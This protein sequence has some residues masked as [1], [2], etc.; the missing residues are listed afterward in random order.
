MA[1]KATGIVAYNALHIMKRLGLILVFGLGA[2]VVV[3]GQGTLD[4][5]LQDQLKKLFPNATSFSSKIAEP[6][7]YKAY[8]GDPKAPE[9]LIGLAFWTTELT[10]LDRGYD[11]PI[12]VLVGMTPQ[13]RL[14]GIV[15]AE[16]KEPYGDFSIDTARFQDQFRNK[17]IRDQFKVGTDINAIATATISITTVARSVRNSGRRVAR[18]L[19]TPPGTQ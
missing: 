15:V 10:P 17:D 18:A 8:A 1:T 11:G 3:N 12:K 5:K 2:L 4:K 14:T 13:A 7:H 16:H 19:L 6:P 9:S